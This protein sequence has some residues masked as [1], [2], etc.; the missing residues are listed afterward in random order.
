MKTNIWLRECVYKRVTPKGQKP[1]SAISMITF[2]TSAFWTKCRIVV[3]WW[4]HHNHCPTRSRQH[5]SFAPYPNEQ[6][7]IAKKLYDLAGTVLTVIVLGCKKHVKSGTHSVW[8]TMTQ[9][10][11]C[12][13]QDAEEHKLQL[14]NLQRE[15]VIAVDSEGPTTAYN[16]KEV[17]GEGWVLHIYQS[18]YVFL[19]NRE[20]Q[21]N[22]GV[23]MIYTR[24]LTST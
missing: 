18:F 16:V 2:L 20:Y 11:L 12:T 14:E 9:A 19:H 15:L 22:G 4:A 6:P 8:Q 1:G 17:D 5:P 7:S 3:P 13:N 24:P 21:E 23:Y 10:I